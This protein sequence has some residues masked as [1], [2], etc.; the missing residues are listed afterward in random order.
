M[1]RTAHWK[2]LAATLLILGTVNCFE[3]KKEDNNDQINTI[4]AVVN[5][6][7]L[8]VAGNWSAYNG[9]TSYAGDAFNSA[10]TVKTG[11]YTIT[12]YTFKQVS[13][14]STYEANIVE[15]NNTTQVMY[16]Q[17]T[18][19]PFGAAGKFSAYYWNR[20]SD[21]KF[22]LCGDLTGNKNTLDAIKASTQSNDKTNMNTGCY[23][24]NTFTPGTGFVWNRFESR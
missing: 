17:F 11:E 23:T 13:G 7:N 4:L 18:V 10:G 22:Y 12:N 20:F 21:N 16:V 1:K 14:S 6:S 5:A 15:Y 3:T 19:H 2:L 24:N 8:Q 9:T